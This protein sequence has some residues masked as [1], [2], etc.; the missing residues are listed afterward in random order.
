MEALPIDGL[1]IEAIE[2]FGKK[3]AKAKG[4]KVEQLT[5][6]I[7]YQADGKP[8]FGTLIDGK[9]E[10]PATGGRSRKFEIGEVSATLEEED[11]E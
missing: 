4:I 1:I 10:D 6:A 8:Y 7:K 11:D 5:V 3:E 9:W 2:R